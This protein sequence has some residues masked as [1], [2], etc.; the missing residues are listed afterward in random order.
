MKILQKYAIW[1]LAIV[2]ILLSVFLITRAT[3]I[4]S[5]TLEYIGYGLLGLFVFTLSAFVLIFSIFNKFNDE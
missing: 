2:A 1:L 4:N 3:Q 5:T